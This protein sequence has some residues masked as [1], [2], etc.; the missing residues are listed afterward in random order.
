MM[1]QAIRVTCDTKAAFQEI[2]R[3]S[4]KHH[5]GIGRV[6]EDVFIV[7]QEILE[8]LH[9]NGTSYELATLTADEIKS[10]QALSALAGLRL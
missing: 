6:R 3:L 7:P 9:R 5:L 4:L 2:F 8:E 10:A 1:H